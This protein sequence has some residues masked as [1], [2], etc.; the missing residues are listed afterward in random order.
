MFGIFKDTAGE[1]QPVAVGMHAEWTG[2]GKANPQVYRTP[3]G[4]AKFAHVGAVEGAQLAHRLDDDGKGFVLV[5][6]IPRAALAATHA[7]AAP[8]AFARS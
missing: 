3:V 2:R 4:E 8:A 6:A 1:P 7:A 5:A